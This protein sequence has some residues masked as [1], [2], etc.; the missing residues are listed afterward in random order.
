MVNNFVGVF[1]ILLP[2]VVLFRVATLHIAYV[3][4]VLR[5]GKGEG[6]GKDESAKC[7]RI[8]VPSPPVLIFTFVPLFL[9]PVTQATL[10]NVI[11]TYIHACMHAYIHTYIHTLY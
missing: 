2:R 3:V 10:H 4:G 1:I 6:K 7:G 5:G 11:V 8:V 9:W